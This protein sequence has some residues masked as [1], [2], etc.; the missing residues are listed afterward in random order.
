MVS[1]AKVRSTTQHTV[2]SPEPCSVGR[3]DQEVLHQDADRA[4]SVSAHS[5]FSLVV[6]YRQALL[7]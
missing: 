3:V 7:G 6:L 4:D 5:V 1:Q 2:P